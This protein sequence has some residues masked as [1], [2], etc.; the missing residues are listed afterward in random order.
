MDAEALYA[1]LKQLAGN[2]PQ[3]GNRAQNH[4]TPEAREWLARLHALLNQPRFGI[5]AIEVHVAT[6]GLGTALHDTN[7]QVIMNALYRALAAVE[8]ELPVAARGAFIAA[9][10]AFDAAAAA[11]KIL[12]EART[13]ALIVDPYLGAKVLDTFALLVPEGV[14]VDLL[15][16]KGK[17]K[18]ALEPLARAWMKQHG[19]SRPLQLRL[20]D[21]RQLHDR[22]IIVDDQSVWDVSQSFED[23]ASRSPATLAKA[24]AELAVLKVEAYSDIFLAAENAELS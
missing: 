10:N 15:A 11:A 22:L 7:V 6:D 19:A 1:H 17:V 18:A 21:E 24:E 13:R 14:R 9:G 16:A 4:I 12:Q 3:L 8:L 5:A 23:L 2:V 20:T